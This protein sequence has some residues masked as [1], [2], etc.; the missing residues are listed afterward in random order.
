MVRWSIT[1][2]AYSQLLFWRPVPGFQP[3][4]DAYAPAVALVELGAERFRDLQR[5]GLLR[6]DIPAVDIQR[7]WTI[8]TAG[9]VSQQLSN[10]PQEPFETGTFTS[11]LPEV[12]AMFARHYAPDPSV[13]AP[14]AK[15]RARRADSR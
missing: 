14:P 12:V 15:R 7:D 3:S 5:R 1:N 8:V 13:P 4:P 9:V 11:R 10:A 6:A 2:A